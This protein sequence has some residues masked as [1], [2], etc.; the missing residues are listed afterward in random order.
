MF[1]EHPCRYSH[2]RRFLPPK[3]SRCPAPAPCPTIH[4]DVSL[5]P[6]L[7]ES[8]KPP[9]SAARMKL[10]VKRKK[11]RSKRRRAEA[12]ARNRGLYSP[13][14]RRESE[15]EDE[16]AE[17][18]GFLRGEAKEL[19]CQGVKPWDDDAWVSSSELFFLSSLMICPLQAVMDALSSGF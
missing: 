12:M 9:K 4:I 1:G 13:Y 19:A 3:M 10:D 18:F 2:D 5:A 16:R 11:Q 17:N 14:G 6:I 7:A 8:T 15:W